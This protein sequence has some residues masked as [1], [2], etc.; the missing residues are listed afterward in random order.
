MAEPGNVYPDSFR[1]IQDRYPGWNLNLL[2]VNGQS[3]H[4]HFYPSLEILYNWKVD[5]L[6]AFLVGMHPGNLQGYLPVNA[7]PFQI[8]SYR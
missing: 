6:P 3:N 4:F 5:I 7:S 2:S 8:H 1:R